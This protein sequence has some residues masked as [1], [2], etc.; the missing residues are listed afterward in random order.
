MPRLSSMVV[1]FSICFVVSGCTP[2]G[3]SF[4]PTPTGPFEPPPSPPLLVGQLSVRIVYPPVDGPGAEAGESV[5]FRAREGY[6]VQSTDSAF[7]FGAV[8]RADADLLVNGK[9]VPVYPSGGWIAWLPLPDDSVAHFDVIATV[10]ADTA[11]L[12]LVA[13]IAG[14]SQPHD[15][16]V[17][18]DSTS[19]TPSGDRWVRPGEGVRLTLRATPGADVRAHTS[20]SEVI[21]FL[22]DTNPAVL[23]WGELAFSTRAPEGGKPPATTDRYVAWWTGKLGPDPAIVMAPDFLPEPT[24]SSWLNV[25]AV[26]GADTARAHWPLRLGLVDMRN[27]LVVVVN[28]DPDGAGRTD[29]VLAGRPSP[30]GTYHWFFPNGTLARVSGRWD[31]QV[32]LQLSETSTAWVDESGVHPLPPGTPPPGGVAHSPRLTSGGQSVVLRIPLPAR[33][34]FHVEEDGTRLGVRLYGVAAD[35]DWIQYGGTDPLIELISFSQPNEDETMV[36][37][38]LSTRVWGY[39]TRWSGN[40]LMIEIR[41]PPE[42]DPKRPLAGR[43]IAVDA[44]H[45]PGGATGPTGTPE[46][47]VTYE[48]AQKVGELLEQFGAQ[49]ILVRESEAPMGLYERIAVAE[50][51]GAE[52]MVSIHANALPDGVNPFSNNGTSV[53]Y[54]HPRSVGLAR[55]LNRALVRQFGFRDL[56]IGRGNLALARPTWMPSALTEGL[57]LMLPDQEAVLVSEEGQWRYARG[58]VEGIAAFLREWALHAN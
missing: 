56:G 21:R 38:V 23:P 53:Y 35:I 19:F 39:R 4:Q 45:P 2:F 42:L 26:V 6:S 3:P 8:G 22:P 20:D 58:V 1:T 52:I 7:V 15:V 16:V 12:V 13:P 33:I 43:R 18:I 48:V 41:R 47:K 17:W 55:E 5:V 50:T 32:R 49:P 46:S 29:G 9:P 30:W 36:T 25:T 28:D 24:D 37:V 57:F 11:R 34:P 54:F 31:D 27:P 14:V 10:G 40:D 44:G 51:A